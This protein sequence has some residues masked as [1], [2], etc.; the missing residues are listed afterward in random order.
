MET[1]LVKET[2][3][4]PCDYTLLCLCVCEL[5]HLLVKHNY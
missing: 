2:Q 4:E 3:L 1:S 5:S